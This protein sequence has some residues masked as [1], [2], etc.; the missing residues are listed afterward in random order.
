MPNFTILIGGQEVVVNRGNSRAAIIA[1]F[2]QLEVDYAQGTHVLIE[3]E[4]GEAAE[5]VVERGRQDDPFDEV[6]VV[7]T[8]RGPIPTEEPANAAPASAAPANAAP[9]RVRRT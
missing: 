4:L 7:K 1:A 6:P 8:P 9:A 2:N 3:N 5:V